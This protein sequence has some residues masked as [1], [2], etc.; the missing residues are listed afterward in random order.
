LRARKKQQSQ[1]HTFCSTEN[2]L[3]KEGDQEG[4]EEEKHKEEEKDKDNKGEDGKREK[5]G[6]ESTLNNDLQSDHI[7]LFLNELYGD[8]GWNNFKLFYDST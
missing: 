3:E 4:E 8:G 7:K 2:N 5:D 6:T 1:T